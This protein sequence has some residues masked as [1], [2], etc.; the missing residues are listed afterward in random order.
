M[1]VNKESIAIQ[2]RSLL[3]RYAWSPTSNERNASRKHKHP[4]VTKALTAMVKVDR[5]QMIAETTWRNR[6]DRTRENR[7]EQNRTIQMI[8]TN[9]DLPNAF[10]SCTALVGW[11]TPSCFEIS[12]KTW[13]ERKNPSRWSRNIMTSPG[14]SIINC[15][16]Q[17]R[18]SLSRFCPKSWS[19]R[20]FF[21]GT[22]STSWS[23]QIMS[24]RVHSIMSCNACL[25]RSVFFWNLYNTLSWTSFSEKKTS[26]DQ[27]N[28]WV[29]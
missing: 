10:K 1:S 27:A 14:H 15:D 20:S 29:S 13:S 16:F 28:L 18:G 3:F 2:E 19:K 8:E 7:A 12:L 11:A 26:S 9:Y 24:S 25:S 22:T 4:M 6:T 17:L 23:R 5:E 21:R